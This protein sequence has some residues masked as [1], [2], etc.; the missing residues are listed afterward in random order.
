LSDILVDCKELNC[1]F[2]GEACEVTPEDCPRRGNEIDEE[3]AIRTAR[4]KTSGLSV[5]LLKE[6][7]IP[8]LE[9]AG[10]AKKSK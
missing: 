8:L 9:R 10:K 1:P 4:R 3:R 2:L 7:I 5:K 6:K